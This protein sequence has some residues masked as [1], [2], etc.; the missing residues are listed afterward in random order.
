MEKHTNCLY[1]G[2]A[3]HQLGLTCDHNLKTI[4]VDEKKKKKK[5]LILVQTV[6]TADFGV[7]E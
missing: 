3:I 2:Q 5:S 7:I 4:D 6:A 1:Q